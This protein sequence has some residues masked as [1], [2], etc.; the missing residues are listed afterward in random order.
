MRRVS[1]CAMAVAL[2]TG[3]AEPVFVG[4]AELDP[5]LDQPGA[6]AVIQ[7]GLAL[8][9]T[10]SAGELSPG[11]PVQL[12][13]RLAN[14]NT[15]RVRL[16][17]NS[18]CQVLLYVE[19]ASGVVVYPDGGGWVCTAALTSLEMAAGE[20]Q[21]QTFVWTGQQSRFDRGGNPAPVALPAGTYRAYVALEGTRDGAK[22][23]LRSQPIALTVR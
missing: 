23:S 19:N 4:P 22:V 21:E 1:A 20:V 10:A 5:R 12:T 13:A 17:F 2:L 14:Q 7:G 18:G 8:S 9:L 11:E 6:P 3:C 15:H 16:D